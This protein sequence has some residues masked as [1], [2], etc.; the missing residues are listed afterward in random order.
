MQ[1][2]FLHALRIGGNGG[3]FNRYTVLLVGKRRIHGDPVIRGVPVGK[4]EIVILG[5]EID[6]RKDQHVLDHLPEN[7]GHFVAV[8]LYKRRCHADLFHSFPS[9]PALPPASVF[10]ARPQIS[11]ARKRSILSTLPGML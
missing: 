11:G 2:V 4:A 5:F 1:I 8:H 10:Q 6:K 9:L 7:S 3:A